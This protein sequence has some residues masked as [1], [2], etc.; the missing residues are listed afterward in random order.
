[1]TFATALLAAAEE[2]HV[3]LALPLWAYGVIPLVLFA[4]LAFVL[5]NYRNVAHRHVFKA[6]AYAAT[7]TGA[8]GPDHSIPPYPGH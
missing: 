2:E 4:V 7:H 6:E 8:T 3:A 1:M 5:W